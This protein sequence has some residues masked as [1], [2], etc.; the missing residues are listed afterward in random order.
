MDTPLLE[1]KVYLGKTDY[2]MLGIM[3]LVSMGIGIFF[4]VSGNKNK[5][6]V[7][8]LLGSR[9]LG[10]IPVCLSL[11]ATFQSAISLL[12]TPAE[13]YTYGTMVM[14]GTVGTVISYAIAAVTVVPLFHP[15][16]ITSVYEYLEMR[17]Q[18]RAVRLLGTFIGVISSI[19][20]MTVA[21]LSPALALQTAV[22]FPLWLSIMLVG[23][24]GTL[25]TAIGGIKSVVWTDVFQ[26]VIIFGGIIVI[27]I[28]GSIDVGGMSKVVEIAN[29]NGRIIF[30]EISPDPRVRHTV[31]GM[32]IGVSIY[33]SGAHF[34][35][36]SVQRIVA[37]KSKV[38][39]RNMFVMAVPLVIVYACIML[40]TGLVLLAYF[41][42]LE[43]DPLRGG[44]ITNRNQLMPYFVMHSLSFL[45][46]LPGLYMATIFSGALSTL[47]SGI[48]SLTANTVEDFLGG[49]LANKRE[50]TVTAISKIIVCIYGFGIIGLA[51]LAREMSG[52]VTQS[53]YTALGATTGPLLGIFILGA[54]FPQANALGTIFGIFTGLLSSIWISVGSF[55]YATATQPLPYGSIE[56]CSSQNTSASVDSWNSSLVVQMSD[57]RTSVTSIGA[58]VTLATTNSTMMQRSVYDGFSM[59]DISYVWSPVIGMIATVIPGLMASII[60]GYCRQSQQKTDSRLLFPFI[61]RFYTMDT[62]SLDN[63]L[64]LQSHLVVN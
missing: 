55:M 64:E 44:Y 56:K 32:C 18:S 40:L 28:K 42:N 63:E 35:Q 38:Q 24:V 62:V 61:R 39:A 3:L 59:Y 10:A 2:V 52:P 46:G 43:C 49:V 48:N 37:I 4:A 8:Y 16:R 20:Y 13:V 51:Y 5:T 50:S 21:L 29:S 22:E 53:T 19:S 30:D 1:N 9:S 57:A 14:Y 47:S 12:G 11:F 34:S 26:T 36:S 25:Y 6:K 23:I 27:L 7:E 41:F 60:Y 33:W 54:T 15:L 17:F 45:P 31:W 58:S